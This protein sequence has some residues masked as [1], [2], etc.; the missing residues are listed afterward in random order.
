MVVKDK[1]IEK[2]FI[3]G[4]GIT[5]DSGPDPFEVSDAETMVAYLKSV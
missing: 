1:V 2:I 5:Q 4:G 3:E